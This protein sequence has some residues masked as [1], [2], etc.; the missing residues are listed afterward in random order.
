VAVTS[1]AARVLVMAKT[2]DATLRLGKG[3]VGWAA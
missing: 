2:L 3:P 1:G